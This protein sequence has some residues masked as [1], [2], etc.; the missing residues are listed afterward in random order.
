V[1]AAKFA[2]GIAVL[3]TQNEKLRGFDM[4]KF[5]DRSFTKGA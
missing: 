5:I 4:A 2:D 3:A 1:P